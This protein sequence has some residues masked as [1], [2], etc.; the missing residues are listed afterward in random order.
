MYVKSSAHWVV[1]HCII[2]ELFMVI[3]HYDNNRSPRLSLSL[4]LTSILAEWLPNCIALFFRWLASTN[5]TFLAASRNNI[6]SPRPNSSLGSNLKCTGKAAR[7]ETT[8]SDRKGC[9]VSFPCE[10]MI[11]SSRPRFRVGMRSISSWSCVYC[12]LCRNCVYQDSVYF[13]YDCSPSSLSECGSMASISSKQLIGSQ[14]IQKD[15]RRTRVWFRRCSCA[16][17]YLAHPPWS[18]V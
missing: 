9:R 7:K 4:P 3:H 12:K 17:P 16:T 8:E 1:S 13:I 15:S 14:T 5:P 18:E 11:R 2:H 6:L 10:E